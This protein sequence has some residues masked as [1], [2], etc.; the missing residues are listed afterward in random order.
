MAITNESRNTV[1]VA[2]EARS[3][4]GWNYDD[5]YLTYDEEFDPQTGMPVFYDGIGITPVITNESRNAASVTNE[6][7]NSV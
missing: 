2:N 5:P 4:S 1:T 6:D 3:G 7:K